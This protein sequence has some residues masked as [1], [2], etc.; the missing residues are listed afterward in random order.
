MDNFTN[1]SY[2]AYKNKKQ[3]TKKMKQCVIKDTNNGLEI[4]PNNKKRQP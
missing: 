4:K 1:S 2:K 3:K